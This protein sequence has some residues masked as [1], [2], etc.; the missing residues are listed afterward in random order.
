MAD[1]QAVLDRKRSLVSK[2]SHEGEVMKNVLQ[3]LALLVMGATS[4][5]AQT[6]MP[7]MGG[8]MIEGRSTPEQI[9][10]IVAFRVWLT[11]N[12]PNQGPITIYQVGLHLP[13]ADATVLA[14]AVSTYQASPVTKHGA[15]VDWPTHYGLAQ[16]LWGTLLSQLSPAGLAKFLAYLQDERKGMN[17][18]PFDYG[19]GQVATHNLKE[20][21]MVAGMPQQHG[22][23]F[24]YSS[25]FSQTLGPTANNLDSFH[26]A[27]GPPGSPW[28]VETGAFQIQS[29]VLVPSTLPAIM[30]YNS[31][32]SCTTCDAEITISGNLGTNNSNTTGPAIRM[33][34]SAQTF[35]V[36]SAAAGRSTGDGI[37][38]YKYINGTPT[39]LGSFSVTVNVGDTVAIV[40][41]GSD[42]QAIYN[43]VAVIDVT[44]TS[45][46]S[47]YTGIAS[48][49][50]TA[51]Y[52]S[53]F[54]SGNGYT[55]YQNA[56][57]SGSTTCNI[58]SG[59]SIY[60][61]VT[62]QGQSANS[63]STL[64]NTYNASPVPYQNYI[65]TQNP[66]WFPY[67]PTFTWWDDVTGNYWVEIICS[68]EGA[69]WTVGFDQGGGG[70]GIA[71]NIRRRITLSQNTAK[72]F[73]TTG[74]VLAPQCSTSSSP[75]DFNMDTIYAIDGSQVPY[76]SYYK[77]NTVCTRSANATAGTPWICSP[78][79]LYLSLTTGQAVTEIFNNGDGH[80]YF[81]SNYDK[82]I[83]GLP[84]P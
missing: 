84:W 67:D 35:Y 50:G 62:H 24:N 81:C 30:Y 74:W 60:N 37:Y 68:L 66:Q 65:N 16:K 49:S 9:P 42:L 76:S 31:G 44:D 47:G 28:V 33:S 39:Q 5:L 79:P 45:I 70:G 69:F 36:A 20:A 12:P 59:C 80:G 6:S 43:G 34:T 52:I 1:A 51:P 15:M 22:M 4:A 40:G 57:V 21:S 23:I 8:Q 41:I 72:T 19:L 13:I 2:R 11:G 14:N 38:L 64:G 73:L 78:T 18:S 58:P 29:D 10:D 25:S 55:L 32:G 54:L 26:R 17:I 3:V 83:S 48:Q 27:N 71:M 61:G 82:G 77:G 56:T 46:T 7:M 53:A 63:I 75:P